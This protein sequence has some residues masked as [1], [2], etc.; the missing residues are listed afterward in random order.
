M[1]ERFSNRRAFSAT[2][3]ILCGFL[4]FSADLRGDELAC[5]C[6]EGVCGCVRRAELKGWQIVESKSFRIHHVG[7]SSVAERLA[8]L[9]EQTRLS[10]QRRWLDGTAKSDWSPQ[11][12]LFLY[13]SGAE[14]Q[15]QT[16]FPM[17]TWG[18]AD[19]EIG[20]GNVWL[21]RLHVRADN[22][23][24]LDKLLIHELTHVVLADHFA[25][26]Q[27]PRWADEGIA[28][29]S[30]PV[31][32]RNESRR[33]LE[34]VA[35][36]GRIFSLK[37]LASQRYVPRDKRLG[38]LFYAQSAALI[39]FLLT[40]RKLSE[41]E[42]LHFVSES[43]SRGLNVTISR[44]FSDVTMTELES[45]WRQWMTTSRTDIQLAEDEPRSDSGV[46]RPGLLTD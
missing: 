46:A 34:Q 2:L 31:A 44:W 45:E 15:R 27:I 20:D 1:L 8:P 41:S 26:H 3:L 29:L 21:R 9:C 12:D 37:E 19:L 10:L 28:V 7:Q 23:Q 4:S 39:E 18:F 40:E 35:A 25:K 11:C 38:D 16:R 36:Q 43:E 17:E 42:L 13:P 5:G 6:R 33:W 32:R 14:F 24:R 22:A 30:E